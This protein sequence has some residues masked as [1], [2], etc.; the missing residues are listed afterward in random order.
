MNDPK[1][2][3]SLESLCFFIDAQMMPLFNSPILGGPEASATKQTLKMPQWQTP[4][5]FFFFFF[6]HTFQVNY[7]SS[8]LCGC[9]YP[10]QKYP[11][12]LPLKIIY[13][14]AGKSSRPLRC[15][16]MLESCVRLW[17]NKG[18]APHSVHTQTNFFMAH[19]TRH[20]FQWA[21]WGLKPALTQLLSSRKQLM[22]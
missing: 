12:A 9:Y 19:S 6:A 3:G 16:S 1:I 7:T 15:L 8:R 13:R 21:D 18:W 5:I 11:Y 22:G 4:G 2:L 14:R 17:W 20:T 10:G